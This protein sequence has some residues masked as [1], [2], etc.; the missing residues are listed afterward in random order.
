[1][2]T[3]ISGNIRARA[4]KLRDN[5]SNHSMQLIVVLEFCHAF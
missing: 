5:V 1:M 4:I 2:N 3:Q